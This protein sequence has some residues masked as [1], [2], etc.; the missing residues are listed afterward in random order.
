M[1][2][3]EAGDQRQQHLAHHQEGGPGQRRKGDDDGAEARQG[4]LKAPPV[5]RHQ[6]QGN[7]RQH[8][9]YQQQA[10]HDFAD[11][12]V[13]QHR[14]GQQ[15]HAQDGAR[16]GHRHARDQRLGNAEA[17]RQR[18]PEADREKRRRGA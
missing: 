14:G 5:A 16:K 4:G 10:N 17:K 12:P 15:L 11:V 13:V 8:I 7:D 9:L 18:Q 3:V 2:G 6:H 1:E